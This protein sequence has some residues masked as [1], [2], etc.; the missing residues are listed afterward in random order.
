MSISYVSATVKSNPY[1]LP[2]DLGLLEKVNQ[3]KQTLFYKNADTLKTELT[4]LR[5][6][7]IANP[8]QKA[9]L[10]Q[11]VNSLV[12]QINNVGAIDYSDMNVVNQIESM[13]GQITNDQYVINGIASTKLM[14]QRQALQD[15]MSADAKLSKYIS[16]Q[17]A[18]WDAAY[19]SEYINGGLNASYNG[20]K[21]PTLYVDVATELKKNIEKLHPDLEVVDSG[22]PGHPAILSRTDNQYLSA[23]RVQ[24]MVSANM[25]PQ[26][27]Q[28][29]NING[30]YMM[31]SMPVDQVIEQRNIRQ[32]S[33]EQSYD[34][35]IKTA[36]ETARTG[37]TQAEKNA[38]NQQVISLKGEKAQA[39][40][41]Y[42]Q[43][44]KDINE[45]W[46][47]RQFKANYLGQ[48]V[49]YGEINNL[50]KAY[51][52]SQLKAT[53]VENKEALFD[54]RE[55]AMNI[56]YQLGMAA[57]QL[58]AAKDGSKSGGGVGVFDPNAPET[59]I[60]NMQGDIEL[61]QEELNQNVLQE[62]INNLGLSTDTAYIDFFKS[63][64]E[65][66]NYQQYYDKIGML[67]GVKGISETD[68]ALLAGQNLNVNIK[69]V[70]KIIPVADY[71]SM[72]PDAIKYFRNV[73]SMFIKYSA[74]QEDALNGSGV[75]KTNFI[76]TYNTINDNNLQSQYYKT[77]K[78]DA[79]KYGAEYVAAKSNKKFTQ[80]ELNEIQTYLENPG[81]YVKSQEVLSSGGKNVYNKYS[82]N[83]S[84]AM[85]AAVRKANIIDGDNIITRTASGNYE[86]GQKEF[87]EKDEIRQIGKRRIL[88]GKALTEGNTKIGAALLGSS[89]LEDKNID[90]S[91]ILPLNIETI[92]TTSKEY[93][94][95]NRFKVNFQYNNNKNK[96][97]TGSS[98]IKETDAYNLFGVTAN[99]TPELDQLIYRQPTHRLN[100]EFVQVQNTPQG[101]GSNIFS[102]QVSQ[103]VKGGNLTLVIKNG[104]NEYKLTN[105]NGK[106][107][108]FVAQ[109]R[110]WGK[111]L[112]Q[113]AGAFGSRDKF[114][115]ALE[116]D[117]LK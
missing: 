4:N 19:D 50:V 58:R 114:I 57:L 35:Q 109:A 28:Q 112:I 84:K 67:D 33:I 3:Y 6:T 5:N 106:P 78:Q 36:E 45:N 17:N 10:Q 108:T 96:I 102:Y 23:S 44:L 46:D 81:K 85:E 79:F 95:G 15:K 76:S 30:W 29:L 52:Y 12:N 101:F 37:A 117:S 98:Y 49:A 11:G 115:E 65:G 61:K 116:A 20:P 74:G 91:K 103:P 59:V 34:A 111:A 89:T 18:A 13:G 90:A 43:D 80:A 31:G 42:K 86:R 56:K 94:S 113:N 97:E 82:F 68:M 107:L 26:V 93:E 75:S 55:R 9:R 63:Y 22:I 14:R 110:A 54:Q 62:K 21:T 77:L 64:G 88:D 39:Q 99:P 92:P 73:A 105:I 87:F 47:N 70:N 66:A 69:G 71:L 8:E 32:N 2:V 27:R 104:N 40:S 25:T 51:S 1:V 53:Q 48:Q 38:A 24:A 100:P 41:S 72:G 16:P 60:G 7:D 83:G